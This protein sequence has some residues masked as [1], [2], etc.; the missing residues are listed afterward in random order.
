MITGGTSVRPGSVWSD[1][2]LE[3]RVEVDEDGV[4]RLSY[5]A[6]PESRR[7]VTVAEERHAREDGRRTMGLPLLDVVVAGSGRNWSGGRYS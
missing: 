5:L 2:A 7:T 6:P 1:D 3:V 4:A